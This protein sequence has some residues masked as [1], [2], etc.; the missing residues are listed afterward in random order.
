MAVI[1]ASDFLAALRANG[2]LTAEQLDEA[3]RHPGAQ[4]GAPYALAEFLEHNG[5]LTRFQVEQVMRGQGDQLVLGPYR[6]IDRLGKGA[7]GELFKAHYAATNSPVTI[8]PS[9]IAPTAA[10]ASA[11]PAIR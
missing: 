7:R 6:L 3:A 1:S 8:V 4:E 5:W 2:L 10:K 9:S 11:L